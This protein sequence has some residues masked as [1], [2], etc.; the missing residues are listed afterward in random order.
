MD[1]QDD[2]DDDD[3]REIAHTRSP[4]LKS[5]TPSPISSTSPEI[6]VPR[7]AGNAW[8]KMPYLCIFQSTGFNA[9][10]CTFTKISPEPGFGTGMSSTTSPPNFAFRRR[11]F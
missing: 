7:M 11:A 3:D 2:D 9:A 8:T 6:S 4:F 5:L 1:C 10:A